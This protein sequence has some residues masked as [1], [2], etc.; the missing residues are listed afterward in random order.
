MAKSIVTIIVLQA[1]K[2]KHFSKVR[3]LAKSARSRFQIIQEDWSPMGTKASIILSLYM[4]LF[5]WQQD[6]MSRKEISLCYSIS[7]LHYQKYYCHWIQRISS[8]HNKMF[9]R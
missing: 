4:T 3:Q 7:Q 1:I 2:R 5:L 6:V 9:G 8:R